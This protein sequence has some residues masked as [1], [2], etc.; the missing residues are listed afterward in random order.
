MSKNRIWFVKNRSFVKKQIWFVK[1][2]IFETR[3][4]GSQ[5]FHDHQHEHAD[6]KDHAHLHEHSDR[7]LT[8]DDH[9]GEPIPQTAE[10]V[11]HVTDLIDE[12]MRLFHTHEH[13]PQ[14]K[15]IR[16]L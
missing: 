15:I 13:Q 7:V 4:Q 12:G 16:K 9:E 14:F 2:H 8:H 1:N 6:G 3:N 10:E 5:S 11:E